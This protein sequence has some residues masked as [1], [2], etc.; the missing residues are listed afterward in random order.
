MG[1]WAGNITGAGVMAIITPDLVE[2]MVSD[3]QVSASWRS[4]AKYLALSNYIPSLEVSRRTRKT[5]SH[6]MKELLIIWRSLRPDT[7][8]V[9]IL[10]KMLETL[11]MKGMYEWIHLMTK[12]RL[13]PNS[14]PS[15]VFTRLN[16]SQHSLLS[17]D[18]CDWRTLHNDSPSTHYYNT[19]IHTTPT[20]SRPHSAMSEDFSMNYSRSSISPRRDLR[21][22][23]LRLTSTPIKQQ[24][25]D[26]V[27]TGGSGG[28]FQTLYC[29][30]TVKRRH[31]TPTKLSYRHSSYTPHL[32][33]DTGTEDLSIIEESPKIELKQFDEAF[34]KYKARETSSNRIETEKYFDN[35][36]V[37]L[38]EVTKGLD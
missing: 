26:Y 27:K 8:T 22:P 20:H 19:S 36:L 14:L 2:W 16:N 21:S 28:V 32:T 13:S 24:R 5:D 4:M 25:G 23:S 31:P 9:D 10:L 15:Y 34:A 29:P 1:S 7:Y 6:R 17:E 3:P 35:L 11:G 30:Q 37:F 38:S 12:D 33:R 18:R